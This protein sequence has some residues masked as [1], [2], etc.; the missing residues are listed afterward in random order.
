MFWQL[1]ETIKD[2]SA[3]LGSCNPLSIDHNGS[4]VF[5]LLETEIA[6]ECS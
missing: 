5:N 4:S 2:R 3:E 1:A 6:Y